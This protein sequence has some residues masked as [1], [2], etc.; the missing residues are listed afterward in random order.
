MDRISK[1]EVFKI[2]IYAGEIML[3]NGAETYRV[4]DTINIICKSKNLGNVNSFVTPTGLF[5]SDNKADGISLIKR[6]E[7]RTIDLDKISKVNSFARDFVKFPMGYMHALSLL[8]EIDAT[9]K[10]NPILK[11]LAV[12]M[13]SAFFALI[14]GGQ[15]ID[16][17]VTLLISTLSIIVYENISKISDTAFLSTAVCSS[18]VAFCS[19]LLH[20]IGFGQNLDMII[21]GAIMP[22]VP[23]VALTNGIRDLI[24]GDLISGMARVCEAI[25]IAIS[26]AVGV[27]WILKV[28]V[29]AF[30]GVL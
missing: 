20:L 2:A 11:F 22:L 29:S 15:P 25:L 9:P 7:S 28:W 6:V 4:E 1:S 19:I 30:G 21:V 13:A 10:Y 26:I 18:I 27:G 24:S 3:K 5:V 14:I 16:F 8:D 17:A 23:G 12:G